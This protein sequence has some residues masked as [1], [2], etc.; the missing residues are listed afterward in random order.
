M[1]KEK[2]RYLTDLGCLSIAGSLD[3][4]WAPLGEADAEQ[5]QHVVVGC[6]DINMGFD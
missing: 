4:V 2:K 1:W 3:L 5:T 6:L